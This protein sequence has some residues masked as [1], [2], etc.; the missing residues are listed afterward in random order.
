MKKGLP[1]RGNG[2][3]LRNCD[4]V[5]VSSC[6]QVHL[7]DKAYSIMQSVARKDPNS[8]FIEFGE[9]AARSSVLCSSRGPVLDRVNGGGS[10]V[11]GLF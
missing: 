6:E 2:I 11:T 10:G 9:V 7:L 5:N 4:H 3:S 1:Y 8:T